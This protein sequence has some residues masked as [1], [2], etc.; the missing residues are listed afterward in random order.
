MPIKIMQ[1]WISLKYPESDILL[2]LRT[3]LY[4]CEHIHFQMLKL[5]LN[6]QN[7]TLWVRGGNAC[8]HAF[9][10]SLDFTVHLLKLSVDLTTTSRNVMKCQVESSGKWLV[11]QKPI[12]LTGW[13][14][15]QYFSYNSY[16]KNRWLYIL[17]FAINCFLVDTDCIMFD[18]GDSEYQ[19]QTVHCI[20]P[21]HCHSPTTA[22]ANMPEIQ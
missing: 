20:E 15:S 22:F 16:I 10:F 7:K 17:K 2:A 19:L 13:P 18:V 1:T 11:I 5:Q 14:Y 3:V 21:S 12:F 6:L 4:V 9:S 8:W